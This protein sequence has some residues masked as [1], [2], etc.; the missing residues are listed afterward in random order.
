MTP[1][2]PT[3]GPGSSPSSAAATAV[4][5]AVPATAPAT[6]PATG[7]AGAGSVATAPILP[8]APA[9]PAEQLVSV[10]SPLRAFADGTHQLTLGLQPEGLGGVRAT[11][12]VTG[13]HVAVQ[14]AA[15]DPDG[16]EALRQLLPQL[17][18]LLSA[19]GSSSTTVSLSHGGDQQ[20]PGGHRERNGAAAPGG[21]APEPGAPERSDPAPTPVDER[22]LVDVRI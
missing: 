1:G 6:A 21:G 15:D 7:G 22:R 14:L 5:T 4:P 9:T 18:A 11:I 20:A 10:L 12:S 2:A 3:D 19:D 13:D 16:R 17:R 8:E